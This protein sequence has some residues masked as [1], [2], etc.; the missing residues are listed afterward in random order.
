MSVGA[1]VPARQTFAVSLILLGIVA[2]SWGLGW[3][4]NKA[5]LAYGPPIWVVAVRYVV[6]TVILGA[7]SL[8]LGRLTWPPR[9]DLPVVAS[10][11]LLHMV[12]FG[13]LS[14]IAL[15]YVPAGRSVLLAYTTPFWVFPLAWLVLGEA[16]TARRL[17][18]LAIGIAGL[19]VLFNPMSVDWARPGAALGHGLILVAAF[20]WA[21]SIVYVRAHRWA[22]APF[23]LLFWQSLLAMVACIV[24]A[25]ALEGVP[26]IRWH[27][28]FGLLLLFSGGIGTGVAY[29]ALNTANKALP[30]TTTALGL[31]GV[32]VAGVVCAT[33]ALGETL[34][35]PTL[36]AMVL[37]V[38]GIAVGA[39]AGGGQG[40]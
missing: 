26:Q 32:P 12:G 40:R 16:L 27:F 30:A 6:A 22:S 21:L 18:A 19:L 3:P 4:V 33:L 11:S 2:F 14:S 34:D 1:A 20:A 39:T 35:M 29:W 9:Q 25:F 36:G 24:I 31:L 37:I 28:H 13:V 38:G 23:D 7:I 8:G 17:V 5:M 15:Q 10:V